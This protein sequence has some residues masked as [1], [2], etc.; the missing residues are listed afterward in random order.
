MHPWNL[1][2]EEART[3]QESL[4][5]D[6][7][8][9]GEPSVDTVAG[10]DISVSPDSRIGIASSVLY[11]RS[12]QAIV[13]EV[14]MIGDLSFPYIPGLLAFREAPLML[15]AVMKLSEEPD[16]L[17]VDGHGYAHPRRFGLA[18]HLGLLLDTPSV[19]VA[20][21]PLVGEYDEPGESAGSHTDIWDGEPIGYAYRSLEGA[22][23]IFLSPGHMIGIRHVPDLIKPS[24]SGQTK[25]PE[26]LHR[27]DQLANQ[28]RETLE[29]IGN[30][31][32]DGEPIFLV[33]GSLR[34]LLM[35]TS[36]SDYDVLVTELD[37]Q[38]QKKVEDTFSGRLF[39]L[40]ESRGIYRVAGDDIQ[41]DITTI[42]SDG[43]VDDLNR[44]DFTINSIALDLNQ[45]SWI[46][47]S[48]GR[49]DA[50]DEILRPTSDESI[51]DDPL[52]VLRA[53]RL[54]QYHNL[55]F[56]EEL[57]R[58]IDQHAERLTE[59][60]RERVVDELLRMT[61]GPRVDRW[62]QRMYEDDVLTDVPF[63]RYEASR[64]IEL[65]D[66]WT[67]VLT[68]REPLF[69]ERVHG[70]FHV[71]DGVKAARMIAQRELT[72]WPF[73][74]RIKSI[75]RA[76]YRELP[77]E[78]DFDVLRTSREHLVGRIIGRSLWNGWEAERLDQE[79]SGLSG[80]LEERDQ[81]EKSIVENIKGSD[82]IAREKEERLKEE[83]PILWSKHLQE[84]A[85]RN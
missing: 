71:I 50:E 45:E 33:G 3:L 32:P 43:I 65:I 30:V 35:G 22:N 85:A 51:S 53:Y 47:P 28:Q 59:V 64:D 54:A 46:D 81:L 14:V 31:V 12:D 82:R 78:P 58:Q 11:S 56:H 9:E 34:D 19:G 25:L 61:S 37:E 48:G 20:K 73:H 69:D 67:D 75:V 80:Y 83:L 23:P 15:N 44:R 63:F 8:L 24:L 16:C 7:L 39:P 68:S 60:S 5:S 40:D 49:G 52:R 55:I 57:D 4:A 29:T 26:P 70:D 27:T 66:S 76:S 38:L 13:D 36:P 42:E 62:Y 74:R 17:L 10:L 79:L 18:S 77:E 2:E 1:N 41:L 6:C 21:S 72:S 84:A